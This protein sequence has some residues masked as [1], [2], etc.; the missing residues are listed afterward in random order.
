MIALI[1]ICRCNVL[2]CYVPG[3]WMACKNGIMII[4]PNLQDKASCKYK[5]LGVH[6]DVHMYSTYYQ[7][8]FGTE[9]KKIRIEV[10]GNYEPIKS[11]VF[12]KKY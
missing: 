6:T 12:L 4:L 10:E 11:Y 9:D 3:A 8:E 2:L 1:R 7:T 5:V